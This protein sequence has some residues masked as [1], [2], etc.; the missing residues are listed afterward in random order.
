MKTINPAKSV[1]VFD[2]DDTL[3]YEDDYNESGVIAVSDELLFLY[4]K[5][6]KEELLNARV[7]KNDIWERACNLLSLPLSVKESLLWM[8]RLHCPTIQLDVSTSDIILSIN[9]MV[10]QIVVLTDGRSI[11]QRKKLLALGLLDFPVYISE[12]YQSEKPDIL[13]FRQIMMDY[14]AEQYV[15]IGDNPRKDFQA[16]NT[17]GWNTLGL[18]E[19]GKNIHSQ[20]TGGLSA[21][22]LPQIWFDDMSQIKDWLLSYDSQFS[23]NDN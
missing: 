21:V 17:L 14:S 15:Y 20:K 8:Y 22:N 12:E 10:S 13:R 4:G 3:Y 1:L 7:N 5:D 9:E 6:I 11:S 16:P 19:K 23:N 2:L 18:K